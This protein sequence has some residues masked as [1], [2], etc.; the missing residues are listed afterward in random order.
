VFQVLRVPLDLDF[1]EGDEEGGAGVQDGEQFSAG[2]G[3]VDA[4]FFEQ[5]AACS[6]RV[7]FTGLA[8]PPGEFPEAPMALVGRT[9]A[10]E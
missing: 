3:N 9:L 7:R 10:D 8:L 2:G 4:Q 6:V 5:F 1:K